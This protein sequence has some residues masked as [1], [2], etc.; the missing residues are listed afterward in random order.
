MAKL[1]LLIL[2]SSSF[3]TLEDKYKGQDRKDGKAF[4]DDP[5]KGPEARNRMNRAK[6]LEALRL[7]KDV[8]VHFIVPAGEIHSL[9]V[10]KAMREREDGVQ[11]TLGA[12]APP[13]QKG[14]GIEVGGVGAMPDEWPVRGLGEG[15]TGITLVFKYGRDAK[16]PFTVTIEY[17]FTD[18]IRSR[19]K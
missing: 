2:L 14:T 3:V 10:L 18:P 8:K 12:S 16:K 4:A 5:T 13:G 17:T 6:L 15:Y 1:S 9:P 11:V 19:K 7:H